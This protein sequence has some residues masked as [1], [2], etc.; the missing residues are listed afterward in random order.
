MEQQTETKCPICSANVTKNRTKKE[1]SDIDF[2]NSECFN[3]FYVHT[4]DH[5]LTVI[6]HPKTPWTS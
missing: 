5:K 6:K 2:T 3:E 4:F 1:E